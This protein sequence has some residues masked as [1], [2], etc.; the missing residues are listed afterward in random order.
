[1]KEADVIACEDTRTT[2]VLLRAYD[3]DTP[4]T[5]YHEHNAGRARPKLLARLEHGERIAI[6]SDAGTPLV[7]DPG[8]KLI[9]AA[10]EANIH[11][12]TA[13]GPSAALAA[14]VI[15]GLPTD[16]FLFAG[17][18]PPRPAARRKALSE[19]STVAST[20]V[21]FESARRLPASLA[22]MSALLDDR[23][24]AVVR[25]LTKIHEE[26]LR[27]TL[28][29]L[30]DRFRRSGPP[31]GEIVIV[32]APPSTHAV[33]STELDGLL[34]TTLAGHS[35]RDAVAVVADATGLPRREI[36]KRALTITQGEP[37]GAMEIS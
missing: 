6:V 9:R 10:I 15:S 32:I 33:S 24:A 14:L 34:R 21:I 29:E 11:V 26:V 25:E 27:G 13:P 35:L 1:M 31:K 12:T 8:Y 37:D 30:A 23:Q 4:L 28:S 36:Y 7:S 22:D 18:L 19:L 17:F 20:L 16:R 5:P 3:I 2:S